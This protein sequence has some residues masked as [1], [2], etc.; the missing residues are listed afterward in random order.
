MGIFILFELVS[1]IFITT[2]CLII[3]IAVQVSAIAKK[4]PLLFYLRL[5][6]LDLT[7]SRLRI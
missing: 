3:T 6:S 7:D 5:E 2:L 4:F 1:L